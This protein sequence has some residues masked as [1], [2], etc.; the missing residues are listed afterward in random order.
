MFGQTKLVQK[1]YDNYHMSVDGFFTTPFDNQKLNVGTIHNQM[2]TTAKTGSGTASSSGVVVTGTGTSFSTEVE[3]G[4][5]IYFI[6][7]GQFESRKVVNVQTDTTLSINSR[8]SVD[9]TT[10]TTFYRCSCPSLT[11][12][13]DESVV[14]TFALH[15]KAVAPSVCF[16]TGR[17][18]PKSSHK[19]QFEFQA[20][21]TITGSMASTIMTGGNSDFQNEVK[22]GNTISV[23]GATYQESRKVITINSASEII[24]DKALS[25]TLLAS[26]GQAYIVRQN[27]GTG[28]MS[29]DGVSNVVN[30]TGTRFM[31]D[32]VV[33]YIIAVGNQ[34]RTI[35]HVY[36]HT[37]VAISAPFNAG[38]G[39]IIDSAY[40]YE[41]CMNTAATPKTITFDS[42]EI[43]PG[44]C[45]FK[46]AG[47]VNAGNF[48]YYKI[49]PPHSNQDMRVVLNSMDNQVDLFIRQQYGPD[50]ANYDFRAVGSTSPW[51]IVVPQT[52]IKCQTDVASCTPLWIGVKGLP[53]TGLVT[54]YEVSAYFELNFPSFACAESNAANLSAMCGEIGLLQSGNASFT[55]DSTDFRNLPVMRLTR[56][57]K[58]QTGAVWWQNKMHLAN[59]FETSFTFRISSSCAATVSNIPDENV[60]CGTGDGFAL[61]IYGGDTPNGQIGCGGRALGFASDAANNCTSGI[62]YSFAVEFDTWHN[63]ELHD[64]NVRGQGSISVNASRVS[65]HS[66]AHVAFFSKGTEPNSASHKDQLA[67]TPSI[68]AIADG[69]EHQARLVYIPGATSAAP[70]RMFLYIDDMQSF[71]LTA[72]VRLASQEDYCNADGKTDHCI[73]DAFG[74]AY[75]GFTSATGG[76]GQAHDIRQWNFCDEPNCG[77]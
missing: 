38:N 35:T 6:V 2:F 25:F 53:T 48:A 31:R 76:F 69:H 39:G 74:N 55:H 20:T 77:R 47:Q 49:T 65:M 24:V 16:S 23:Y 62:P 29:N 36:N 11:A 18:V 17:C 46:A 52:S 54:P 75:L 37:A 33:G 28:F 63:P 22:V 12:A 44:C 26:A 1:I 56:D 68:P 42:C 19:E 43:K 5:T 21:G 4:Y 66:F 59:G 3:I 72:P 8:F 64:V 30:G 34:Q 14:G 50:N 61:V 71:V 60:E 51:V 10:P 67:G 15:S 32:L 9:V 7:N 57:L 45:G 73:L 58:Y 70:G 13:A 41:S 27:T 40:S